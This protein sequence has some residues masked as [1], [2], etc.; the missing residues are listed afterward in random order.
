MKCGHM[1][2]TKDLVPVFSFFLQKGRCRYCKS[3]LSLQYPVVELLGGFVFFL[4]FWRTS[5]DY[6]LWSVENIITFLVFA[7]IFST[8]IVMSVY[9]TKHFILPWKIMRLYLIVAF[10]GGI[11][12]AL[13]TGVLAFENFVAGFITAAPFFAIWHF[14]KGKLIGFGDI[15]LMI[16]IGF[17][18]GVQNGYAAILLG[19]WSGLIFIFLKML[20]TRKLLSGK[21]QIPFG[22]FLAF[23]FFITF[24]LGINLSHLLFGI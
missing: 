8:L 9:D 16:G 2:H 3:K 7:F 19:F 1:L 22:P 20:S 23:G 6:G 5:S 17:L 24:V 11:L 13:T 18:M 15:E 10:L 12:L 14:S 4:T 21:T